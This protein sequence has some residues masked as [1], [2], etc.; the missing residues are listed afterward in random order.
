MSWYFNKKETRKQGR[1]RQREEGGE[2][3]KERKTSRR[4]EE[5]IK[6]RS[7]VVGLKWVETIGSSVRR[8]SGK[9]TWYNPFF[10]F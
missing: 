4:R 8:A 5:R 1:E 9:F 6:I 2:K 7:A 10:F 3:G